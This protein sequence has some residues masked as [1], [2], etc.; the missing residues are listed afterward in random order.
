MCNEAS[1]V[2]ESHRTG[3]SQADR[4]V[5]EDRTLYPPSPSRNIPLER[6]RSS[7][8]ITRDVC[9]VRLTTKRSIV[10]CDAHRDVRDDEHLVRVQRRE[11]N[12]RHDSPMLY[13]RVQVAQL[14]GGSGGRESISR[15]PL[16][17]EQVEGLVSLGP[18]SR[19]V[20]GPPRTILLLLLLLSTPR[21]PFVFI[22]LNAAPTLSVFLTHG[23]NNED[24]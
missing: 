7:S 19:A 8:I 4:G 24:N 14:V 12:Q 17:T 1:T 23:T 11:E 9:E 21:L 18:P 2:S 3:V 5:I 6:D 10:P 15:A 13:S 22:L 16:Q 20:K